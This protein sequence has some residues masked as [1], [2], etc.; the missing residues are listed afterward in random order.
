MDTVQEQKRALRG[1]VKAR[2]P[3]P[4][5]AEFVAASVAAQER[6]AVSERARAARVVALY[7]ALPSECGTAALAATL[8]A[9]GKM[10]C[11]PAVVPGALSLQFRRSAGVFV[12]G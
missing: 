8:E 12:S 1:E 5:S 11:Y 6:L 10:V 7:R 9:A 3:G 4:G 2:M